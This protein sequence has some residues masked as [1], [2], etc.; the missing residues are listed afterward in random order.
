MKKG[1]ILCVDDEEGVLQAAA[2]TLRKLGY[3]VI[4]SSNAPEAL[5][6]FK[7]QADGISLVVSDVVMPGVTGNAL[8]KEVRSMSPGTP[9][10]LITGN[11]QLIMNDLTEQAMGIGVK[12]ILEKPFTRLDLCEAIAEALRSL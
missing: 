10:I 7:Q 6:I 1:S 5:E 9:V 3:A 8:A 12:H 11:A 4:A 2:E